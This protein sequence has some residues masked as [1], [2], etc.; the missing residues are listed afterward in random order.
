[1]IVA[2]VG[3]GQEINTG[4]A[5]LAAW[6]EALAARPDWRVSAPA[7]VLGARD[8]RQRLFDALPGGNADRP[9]AASE[10]ADPFDPIHCCCSLGGCGAVR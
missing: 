5:G 9:G 6:G 4:E 8:P 1:M 2:L 7:G 10:R 3:T